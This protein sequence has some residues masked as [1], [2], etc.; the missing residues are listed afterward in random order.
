MKTV[1]PSVN[2]KGCVITNY[3]AVLGE[4]SLLVGLASVLAQEAEERD[5]SGEVLERCAPL[6]ILERLDFSFNFD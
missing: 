5:A 3:C 6:I 4:E 2:N 1:I